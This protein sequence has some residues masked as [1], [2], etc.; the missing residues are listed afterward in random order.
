MTI[1]EM[2]LTVGVFIASISM[3]PRRPRGAHFI[4]PF[5]FGTA[6]FV[7]MRN[8]R[9]DPTLSWVDGVIVVSALVGFAL[10]SHAEG[11]LDP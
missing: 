10:R 4:A 7:S 11:E 3:L 5:V 8:A 9:E 2:M 1:V 6:C